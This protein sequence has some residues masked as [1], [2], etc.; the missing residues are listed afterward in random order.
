M[1]CTYAFAENASE[2]NKESLFTVR[3]DYNISDK[4]KISA[5]YNYDWG[6]QATGPSFINPAFNEQSNQPADNGQLTYT[7]T[8]TPTLVNNFIGSGSWYTAIFGYPSESK[9]LA[10][11]PETISPGDG[12]C[13]SVGTATNFPQGRN[14]GQA[15]FVDD[16]TWIHGKHTVQGRR[17]LPVQQDHRFYQQRSR[18]TTDFTASPI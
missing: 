15:Q 6:L 18:L 17:Q 1:P 4:Q 3:G 7:Y 14:V 11:M 16:L 2:T 9:A 12:C 13:S 5:R 10:L 8:I